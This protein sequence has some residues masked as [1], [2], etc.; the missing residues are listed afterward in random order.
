MRPWTMVAAV[1]MALV[2]GSALAAHGE[3][4]TYTLTI[5]DHRF[6]PTEL[7]LPAGK[8]ITLT[9]KNL[10]PTAEEFESIELHREKVVAGG[11]EIIVYLGPL[12]PGRY[13]FFGDFNPQ[14]A[15]GTIVVK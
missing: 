10:D 13:E 7:E 4:A 1:T 12:R 9:V 2:L 11:Q 5:K 15:R 8:K 3:D 14:T 6:T